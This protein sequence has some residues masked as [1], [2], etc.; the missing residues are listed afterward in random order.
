MLYLYQSNRLEELAHR[1]AQVQNIQPLKDI[2]A[3]ECI[4]IQ[5]QGMRRYISQFLAQEMG[6]AANLK[7]MLPAGLAWKLMR[8]AVPNAPE[9]SPFSSEVMRWRLLQLFQSS[10]FQQPH[11]QAARTVLNDYLN[12]GD[13]AAYQLAGQLADV[14][15]QYLVYRPHWLEAWAANQEVAQLKNDSDA[16]SGAIVAC[17]NETLRR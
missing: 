1:L 11:F 14:L 4:V 2:F 6:I 17:V 16:A 5:S 10:D 15:D 12:N 7:F 9:L 13:Y 8:L 3:P